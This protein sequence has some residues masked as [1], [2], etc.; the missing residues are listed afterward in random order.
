M[1][2]GLIIIALLLVLVMIQFFKARRQ[3][4]RCETILNET[5]QEQEELKKLTQTVR[6]MSI[7]LDVV[8]NKENPNDSGGKRIQQNLH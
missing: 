5:R 7:V 3:C 4:E 2:Q 6:Q 1:N 8:S